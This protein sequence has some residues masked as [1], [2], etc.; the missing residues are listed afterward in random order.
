MATASYWFAMALD[1]EIYRGSFKV[2]RQK[3]RGFSSKWTKASAQCIEVP[4]LR[5]LHK[6]VLRL[7]LHSVAQS[8]RNS[9]RWHAQ[10]PYPLSLFSWPWCQL[11]RNKQARVVNSLNSSKIIMAEWFCLI[12]VLRR[13]CKLWVGK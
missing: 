1:N 2:Q 4:D 12:Q 3:V 13:N 6:H 8:F 10:H 7:A 11:R 5:N 9:C